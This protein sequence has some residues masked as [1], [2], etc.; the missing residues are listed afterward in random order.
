MMLH[1]KVA[2]WRIGPHKV[3]SR[4]DAE[5]VLCGTGQRCMHTHTRTFGVCVCRRESG[6]SLNVNC[7][8]RSEQAGTVSHGQV[9][10]SQGSC[11]LPWPGSRTLYACIQSRAENRSSS[12][13]SKRDK[14]GIRRP[15]ASVTAHARASAAPAHH[16]RGPTGADLK[17]NR[18]VP[19]TATNTCCPRSLTQLRV[20]SQ[21]L[22]CIR[23]SPIFPIKTHV[24]IHSPPC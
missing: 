7:G 9:S 8:C 24:A 16:Q 23:A 18:A 2:Q 20:R 13:I 19:R 10:T 4:R 5:I 1:N 3:L 12:S 21:G 6:G 17:E 14:E 15:T 11:E 22:P